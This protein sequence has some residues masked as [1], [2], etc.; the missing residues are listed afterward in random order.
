MS[1][2]DSV[3]D[4]FIALRVLSKITPNDRIATTHT[5]SLDNNGGWK[6][7]LFFTRWLAG[8]KRT[9]NLDRVRRVLSAMTNHVQTS[10]EL[11]DALSRLQQDKSSFRAGDLIRIEKSRQFIISACSALEAAS[12]GIRNLSTTYKNDDNTLA[13]LEYITNNTD[14]FVASTR[15]RLGTSSTIIPKQPIE[16]T[17]RHITHQHPAFAHSETETDD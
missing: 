16:P 11:F 6:N 17:S 5:I 9:V 1:L 14:A 4:L 7:F 13:K 12:N 15:L 10:L 3:E 8:E 2:D